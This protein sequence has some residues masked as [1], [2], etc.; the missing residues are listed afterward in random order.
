MVQRGVKT[1]IL[2]K[3]ELHRLTETQQTRL[4]VKQD[5]ILRMERP[6]TNHGYYLFIEDDSGWMAEQQD[7]E[8]NI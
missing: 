7:K 2:A 3:Q 8:G 5:E 6:G 4:I 1:E